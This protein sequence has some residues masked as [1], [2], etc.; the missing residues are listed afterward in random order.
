M[1]N[2]SNGQEWGEFVQVTELEKY[3][4]YM[5]T[6]TFL[7]FFRQYLVINVDTLTNICIYTRLHKNVYYMCTYIILSSLHCM[8]VLYIFNPPGT[9]FAEE[10]KVRN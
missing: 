1:S 2:H 6:A 9:V 10:I 8:Y 3:V 5:Y 7:E 4:K